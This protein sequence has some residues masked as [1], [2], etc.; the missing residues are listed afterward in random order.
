[1]GE[2]TRGVFC[3][4]LDTY[5]H[6]HTDDDYP[7]IEQS[8]WP[9]ERAEWLS[10]FDEAEKSQSLDVIRDAVTAALIAWVAEQAKEAASATADST[11]VGT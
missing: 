8:W 4:L 7:I 3:D 1:M 11:D 10:R 5:S 9:A 2:T 6:Q